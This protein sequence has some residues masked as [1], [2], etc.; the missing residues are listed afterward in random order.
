MVE[1]PRC[2]TLALIAGE[3]RCDGS[4]IQLRGPPAA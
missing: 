4:Y 2:L 3:K 1:L